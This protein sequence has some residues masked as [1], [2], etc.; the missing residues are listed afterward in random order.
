MLKIG[1]LPLKISKTA[2]TEVSLE[3][4]LCSKRT[5]IRKYSILFFA[6]LF[7]RPCPVWPTIV[8]GACVL[9]GNS[10]NY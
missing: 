9:I 6:T 1:A 3:L 2:G 5:D 8:V 10:T 4:I 7:K